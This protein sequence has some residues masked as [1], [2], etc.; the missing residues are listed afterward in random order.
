RLPDEHRRP[1]A[2]QGYG[3]EGVPR[4]R[5]AGRAGRDARHRRGRARARALVSV[6]ARSSAAFRRR[7]RKA[8]L[9]GDL[10]A[11][12]KRARGGFVDHRRNAIE[13]LPEFERLRDAANEIR[14]HTLSHL[15]YYLELFERNV[16]A[17]GGTV[18][19]ASTPADLNRIVL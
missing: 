9:D 15:D 2:P 6:V 3:A 18:H 8:L 11:A 12:L 4:R 7:S 5:V 1:P 19:W 16:A 14:E 10:Q 13:A 17:N